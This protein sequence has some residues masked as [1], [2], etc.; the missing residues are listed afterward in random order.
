MYNKTDLKL[1]LFRRD[2]EGHFILIKGTMDLE[3]TTN[4]NIYV[5]NVSLP[6]FIKQIL[7]AIKTDP[8]ATAV[9]DQY[10]ILTNE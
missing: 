8:K 10:P 5:S 9:Y 3:D 7:L 1:K 6:N 2:K 4:V